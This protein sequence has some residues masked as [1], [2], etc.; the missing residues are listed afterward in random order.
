MCHGGLTDLPFTFF[1]SPVSGSW[2]QLKHIPQME[3]EC[4]VICESYS[5]V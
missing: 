1:F 2:L 5:N 4:T 3:G